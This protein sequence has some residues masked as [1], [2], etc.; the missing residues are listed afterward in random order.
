VN[1]AKELLVG[2]STVLIIGGLFLFKRLRGREQD[3]GEAAGPEAE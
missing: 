2:F 1:K 3:S